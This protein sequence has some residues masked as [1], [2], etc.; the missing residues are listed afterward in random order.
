MDTL[1]FQGYQ[2]TQLRHPIARDGSLRL[3]VPLTWKRGKGSSME[4]VQRLVRVDRIQLEQ[5]SGKSLHTLSPTA[6]LLDLN[7][8][9]IGLLEIVT[10][11]DIRSTAEAVEFLRA[12]QRLLRHIGAGDCNMEE[13]S[14]RCDVNVSIRQDMRSSLQVWRSTAAPRTAAF[15]CCSFSPPTPPPRLCACRHHTPPP[16]AHTLCTTGPSISSARE[17]S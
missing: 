1:L 7:R 3:T 6:S 8:A 10:A 17:S 14:L 16:L 4:V 11:P 2:I 12:L 13:G 15:A 9:G 5:D